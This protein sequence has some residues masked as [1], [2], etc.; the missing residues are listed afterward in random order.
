M[1]GRDEWPERQASSCY[2]LALRTLL[3]TT[4]LHKVLLEQVRPLLQVHKMAPSDALESS[5]FIEAFKIP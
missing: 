5:A 4:A 3:A 1:A 2:Q